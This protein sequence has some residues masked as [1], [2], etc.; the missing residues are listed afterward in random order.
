VI[1]SCQ[2]I[3][4]GNEAERHGTYY[5]QPD[6]DDWYL[7]LTHTVWCTPAD[8]AHRKRLGG[9]GM[10]THAMGAKATGNWPDMYRMCLKS[11]LGTSLMLA[12]ES[13]NAIAMGAHLVVVLAMY[14]AWCRLDSESGAG[15]KTDVCRC[16]LALHPGARPE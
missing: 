14:V 2:K 1:P 8:N 6:N 15:G 12:M 13:G 5:V 3:L 4:I 9:T 11:Q 16:I 10:H 7:V